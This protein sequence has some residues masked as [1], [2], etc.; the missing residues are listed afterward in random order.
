MPENIMIDDF[1]TLNGWTNASA[2]ASF[3]RCAGEKPGNSAIKI[4]MPGIVRKNYGKYWFPGSD[5]MDM[6]GFEGISFKVKGDGSDNYG[7]ITASD[8]YGYSYACAFSLKNT[9]WR[10]FCVGWS[11]FIP[12]G[13]FEPVNFSG[14]ALVPSG[15]INF[16]FGTGWKISHNNK[17]IPVHEFCVDDLMFEGKIKDQ[18]VKAKTFL[19]FETVLA[20]LRDKKPVRIFCIG[21]SITVGVGLKNMDRDRYAKALETML[22]EK[23]GYGE[24]YSESK[25]VGGSDLVW[26][27]TWL[28][29]DFDGAK[30]DLVIIHFGYNDKSRKFSAESFGKSLDDYLDRIAG[31]TNGRTSI[32]LLATMP[33][34]GPRFNMLDDY[35]AMVKV[36]AGARKTAC[37]D[38]HETFK[39][40]GKNGVVNYFADLAHPNEKGHELVARKICEMFCGERQA[41]PCVCP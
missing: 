30:P 35:A 1:E 37:V 14:T 27:R 18:A 10:P 33:G 8:R 32:L 7:Y 26:A 39:K 34:R 28:P 2:T 40:M 25:A 13:D 31:D 16:Q 36:V 12:Q 6:D 11:D 22:R 41:A 3:E 15:L 19:P 29:R 20:K 38:L 17:N 5:K 9:Q 4:K 23:F 21:D 24:I